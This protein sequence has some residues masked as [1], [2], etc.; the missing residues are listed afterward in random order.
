TKLGPDTN[1]MVRRAASR[2]LDGEKDRTARYQQRALEL[3]ARERRIATPRYQFHVELDRAHDPPAQG[4]PGIRLG[5]LQDPEDRRFQRPGAPLR[6][7]EQRARHH[8]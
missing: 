6:L 4:M 2:I 1:A 7:A 5:R 3:S 8:P